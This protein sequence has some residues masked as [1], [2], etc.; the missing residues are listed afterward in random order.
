LIFLLHILHILSIDENMNV[1]VNLASIVQPVRAEH[2][3]LLH[4][5]MNSLAH[6][7]SRGK[8][9]GQGFYPGQ[10]PEGCVKVKLHLS[11]VL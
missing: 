11:I 5:R 6:S 7:G 4:H 2:W 10:Q 3:P 8:V 1:G 9:K